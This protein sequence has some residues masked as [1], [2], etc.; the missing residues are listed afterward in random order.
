MINNSDDDI[1]FG[2]NYSLQRNTDDG[3]VDISYKKDVVW[4]TILLMLSK[5][6]KYE[7]DIHLNI[8]D[9]KFGVGVPCCKVFF[10][11]RQEST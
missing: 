6:Q 3:W 8:F 9:Y 11:K 2:T 1:E 7:A 4:T 5:N 10:Y